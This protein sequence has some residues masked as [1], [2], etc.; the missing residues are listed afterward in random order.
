[1]FY[2]IGVARLVENVFTILSTENNLGELFDNPP[3]DL[4][5]YMKKVKRFHYQ[6]KLAKRQTIPWTILMLVI[7][8]IGF[9]LGGAHDTGVVRKIVHSGVIYGFLTT[10]FIGLYRQWIHLGKSHK[11]LR[12]L[13]TTFGLSD[14]SM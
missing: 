4:T 5:P 1:M 10:M 7:G 12:E 3:K 14:D 9:L 8:S 13:K 11:L 6:S 2:F